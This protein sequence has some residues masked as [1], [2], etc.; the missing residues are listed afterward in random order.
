M[1]TDTQPHDNEF[2]KEFAL[3]DGF[4]FRISTAQLWNFHI[5]IFTYFDS[6]LPDLS[7]YHPYP[8]SLYER[9]IT[10]AGLEFRSD[11]LWDHYISWEA[12]IEEYGRV[13][14]LFNKLIT[15]P[16]QQ[17][18][19]NFEKWGLIDFWMFWREPIRKSDQLMGG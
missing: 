11:K 14:A 16:T 9:A 19:A 17:Y 4:S 12:S 15:I 13:Y 10:S 7:F 1:S 8:H 2:Q 3:A 5:S 18:S 6:S